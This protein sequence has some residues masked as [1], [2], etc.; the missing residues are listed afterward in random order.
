M[1]TSD[2]PVILAALETRLQPCPLC[3]G[4]GFEPLARHDRNLLGIVTVGCAQCGLVQTN[5]RPTGRG[6]DDFYRDHYRLY[7][8]HTLSPNA[9]Y[10]A[11]LN[12]DVRLAYTAA[13]LSDQLGVPADAVILDFGCGEGSLFAALRI[14]GFRGAFYGVEPNAPF[15]EFASRYGDATVSS[16]IPVREPVDLIIINHVLEHLADPIRTLA[17]LRGLLKARGSLYV[18]VPDADEYTGIKDLHL[19]HVYHFTERTLKHMIERAGF[20]VQRVQKH[21]PPFHPP[22]VRLVAHVGE[23]ST[24]H[25]APNAVAAER[26]AWAAVRQ[27]GRL[28]N[29]LGLRLRRLAV[30]RHLYRIGKGLFRPS[31]S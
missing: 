24:A 15:A 11:S 12:K 22:S 5:P 1:R 14:A 27:S 10:V 21:R 7:Y 4:T 28:R 3:G 8:Q 23:P 17:Q 9:A 20:A 13:F 2:K 26:A 18:D 29:T 30:I 31:A 6:L 25:A 19:A 16:T